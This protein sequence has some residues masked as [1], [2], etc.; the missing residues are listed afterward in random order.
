MHTFFEVLLIL[1]ACT[2][3]SYTCLPCTWHPAYLPLFSLPFD[4]HEKDHSGKEPLEKD[5]AVAAG[6]SRYRNGGGHG[7]A[8]RVVIVLGAQ[9]GW[10]CSTR[11]G[12]EV[13]LEVFVCIGCVFA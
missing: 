8:S 9:E 10:G 6:Q 11:R 5:A 7:V 1:L 3:P 4:R 2:A 12:E 13:E